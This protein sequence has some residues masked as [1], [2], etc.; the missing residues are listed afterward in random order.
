MRYRVI[1]NPVAGK[2]NGLKVRPIVEEAFQRAGADFEVV[3]TE[4]PGHGAELARDA[5]RAGYDVVVAVGG[6]GTMS[7]AVNGVSGTET[8][9]GVIPAGT[10]NDLARTLG[11]PLDA[12]LGAQYC[13]N[14]D[15]DVMDVGRERESYFACLTSLGFPADVMHYCNTRTGPFRGSLGIAFGVFA[16]LSRLVPTEMEFE[17]DE[18]RTFRQRSTGVF[19]LNTRFVGGGMMVSPEARYNDG[20]LDVVIMKDFGR[21]E[22]TRVLP[23]V[24]RGKHVGH[25]KMELVKCRR[26]KV[27]TP[28]PMVKMYDGNVFGQSPLEATLIPAAL[29]VLVPK[30]N[31]RV[32]R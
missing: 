23:L 1:V 20:L 5:A 4:H 17:V 24:Y 30:P 16:T 26:I 21:L 19:V 8:A 15:F 27:T 28:E 14:P 29:R 32:E 3:L 22:L 10:G 2:G 7:E 11:I 12:R 13:L 6:D 9:L 25:P 31:L 18:G